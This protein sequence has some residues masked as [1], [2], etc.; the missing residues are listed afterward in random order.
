MKEELYELENRHEE[1]I[2]TS[3]Q[4]CRERERETNRQKEQLKDVGKVVNFQQS[5]NR[6]F[7][8]EW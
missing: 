4:K 7:K 8:K 6:S 1:L 2:K 5:V 3:I